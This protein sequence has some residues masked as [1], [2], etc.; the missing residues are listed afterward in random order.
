MNNFNELFELLRKIVD[1]INFNFDE[2]ILAIML[3]FAVA[4]AAQEHN[5]TSDSPCGPEKGDIIEPGRRCYQSVT[6][7]CDQRAV[8]RY[9]TGGF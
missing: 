8:L 4:V 9:N 3:L 2:G 5:G 7:R 1:K 6:A